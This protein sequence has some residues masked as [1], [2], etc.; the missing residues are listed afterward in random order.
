V[1]TWAGDRE[2]HWAQQIVDQSEGQALLAPPTSII[3]LASLLRGARLFVGSDTGPL[4]LAV[5]VGTRCV[6]L[7]GPTRVAQSGPYGEGHVA[8]QE[9]YREQTSRVRRK[10]DNADMRAIQIDSVA[11]ACDIILADQM[12]ER[13]A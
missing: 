2:R 9:V 5:A 13:A 7:H 3:E 6:A 12:S 4:H 8:L 1:A 11:K 10:A